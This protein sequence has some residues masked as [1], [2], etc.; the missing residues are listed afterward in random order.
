MRIRVGCMLQPY[1][2]SSLSRAVRGIVAAGFR[3][4]A[5]VGSFGGN[6]VFDDQTADDELIAMNRMIRDLGLVP[7][8]AWGGDLLSA[9]EERICRR[10]D[11]AAQLEL[12]SLLIPGPWAY[13]DP[14][15]RHR[16]P[17]QVLR[18]EFEQYVELLMRLAP[19]AAARGL[20]F[21]VMPRGGIAGTGRGLSELVTRIGSATLRI[22][23]NPGNTRFFEG[24][25]PI[26][27]I[28][29]IG[30]YLSGICVKDHRGTRHNHDFPTPGDGAVDWRRL[31]ERL[32]T[33]GFDGWMLVE[34]V[35]GNGT[36][37][38]V[39][40]EVARARRRILAWA[41]GVG[42]EIE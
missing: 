23:Y 10:L 11:Q 33:I 26:A 34:E 37:A 7:L 20:R 40:A 14:Q 5:F 4:T 19:E 29:P 12:E 22:A 36:P 16:K 42:A 28:A 3:Y 25:D 13:E 30:A 6:P 38:S 17:Q 31:F 41:R 8:T 9:E 15:A 27:D 1:R 2:N 35:G 39:D 24:V 32:R 21:D 18:D